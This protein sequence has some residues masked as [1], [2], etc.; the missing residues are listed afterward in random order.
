M[1]IKASKLLAAVL[2][3]C[4]TLGT[5]PAASAAALP[6][7]APGSQDITHISCTLRGRTVSWISQAGRHTSTPGSVGK[8]AWPPSARS[9]AELQEK[10]SAYAWTLVDSW[11]DQQNGDWAEVDET[12]SVTPGKTYRVKVTVTV[13]AGSPVREQDLLFQRGG[14]VRHTTKLK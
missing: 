10:A 3:L 14:G 8:P 1:R 12:A 5:A 7:S 13:W 6:Q 2:A 9:G 11:T 4:L